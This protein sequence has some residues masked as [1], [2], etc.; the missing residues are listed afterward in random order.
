MR[1]P[2]SFARADTHINQA[3][4]VDR[5]EP[6]PG[7]NGIVV[8][9]P[10]QTFLWR[11]QVTSRIDEDREITAVRAIKD[12]AREP[13]PQSVPDADGI[14]RLDLAPAH[15]VPKL[16]DGRLRRLA[17]SAVGRA[18]VESGVARVPYPP[19]YPQ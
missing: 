10:G 8:T 17:S 4:L 9:Q 6:K 5:A 2:T 19:H 13:L 12:L 1:D 3:A 14:D 18:A 7:K 11:T 15:I 16:L